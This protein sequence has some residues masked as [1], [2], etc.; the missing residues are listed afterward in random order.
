VEFR[1][2]YQGP[3]P[4]EK[5]E[6]K[7]VVGSGGYGRAKDKHRLRKHFHLQLRELWQQ[8][9]DLRMQ[10][11]QKFIV[12]VTP[13]NQVSDPGPDARQIQRANRLQKDRPDAKT[14]LDHLADQH[15]RCNGNRFVP[16]INEDGGFTCH[17]DILFLRRDN[18]GNLIGNLGDI[19]NRIKVLFDGLRMPRDVKELGGYPIDPD[20]NPFFCLLEDDK[21]IT[22]V[23]VTTDR[24]IIPKQPA[25]DIGDVLLVIH[26]TMVNPSAIFADNR[27]V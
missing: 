22:G 18:P 15:I 5:C 27:L 26:V 8:H 12:H 21:L 7:L 24:L 6:D 17:L 16:L 25:E 2:I 4:S 23:T 1:L 20:E 14:W 11:E 9:P 10:A 19:D 13:S 3:L